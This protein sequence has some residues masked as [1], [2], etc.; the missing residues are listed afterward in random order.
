MKLPN[1]SQKLLISG[2][3]LLAF[4]LRAYRLDFQ[5]YWID[6]G[7]TVF[8]A[9]L[10][11]AELWHLLQVTEIMPP[12]YHPSTIYWI[13][14]A[15]DSEYALRFYSLVFGVLAVPLTYR[16]GKDLGDSRLGLIAAFLMAVSPYQVWHSQEARMYSIFTA[17]SVMSM[18]GFVNLWQRRGPR[19]WAVYIIGTEWAIMTHY[20]AVVL[21][22]IQGL[23]LLL[24]WRKNWRTYPA[25]AA[26]LGV[27]VLLYVPWLIFGSNLL[28]SYINWIEPTP[29]AES[30]LRSAIA[31]SVGELVPRPQ[32]VPLAMVFA[33]VY[34]LGLVYAARRN[35]KNWR[36]PEMLALLVAYTLAPNIAAWVYGELRTVVYFERYLILV[37]VGY[38]LAVSAGVLAVAD[39]LPA[40]IRKTGRPAAAKRAGA[41]AA[42]LVLAVLAGISGW[43][44]Y[45]HYTNPAY[46]KPNWRA[47][48]RTIDAYSLPG[49]AV[50]LT[51][52]GGENLMRFYSQ[53]QTPIYA[54]FNLL[55][56]THP[57]YKKG[58]KG[59][60]ELDQIM[61]GLSARYRRIWFTPYG[62]D[63]DPALEQWLAAHT[64]PAWHNWLGR[65]RLALY[66]TPTQTPALRREQLLAVFGD[67]P[68]ESLTLLSAALPQTAVAAGDVLPLEL[69]W[70][71]NVPPANDYRLS[72]RLVNRQGDIFAQSDWPPLAT[73]GPPSTWPPGQPVSDRRGLWL[74]PDIPPGQYGLQFVV[75]HPGSGRPLGQPANLFG[76]AVSAAAITVAPD[77]L[78]LPN[79]GER[80]L[81]GLN[82]AGYALPETIKPGREMWLW[83]YW[84]APPA[85]LDLPPDTILRLSLSTTEQETPVDFPLAGSVGPF[86]A[87]LPGQVR[88]AVY[89]LPTNPRLTGNQAQLKLA[90]VDAAGRVTAN[91]SLNGPR[92]ETRP[93]R[94]DPPDVEHPAGVAFGHPALLKLV[95]YNVPKNGVAAGN[96]VTV[97]LYWQAVAPINT[98]YTTFVQVLNPAGQVVAQVDMPPQAGNAPTTT[99][100][101]GEFLEDPYSLT[102]PPGLPPGSYRL[103]TGLYNPATAARL[104]VASGGDFVEL[105]PLTVQ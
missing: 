44:L 39:G 77:M 52:D 75:Y 68:E 79:P 49:D 42:G 45:H 9:H 24:T 94:F 41:P 84:Q 36:G 7:W 30:F 72:V 34:G 91:L 96:V 78:S 40:L 92:L 97:T 82:L 62:V 17:T 53:S 70:Q 11:P 25:W 18:W 100:L 43:V 3:A 89:H 50:L 104:P 16:L 90:L 60:A 61:T 67:S 27:M 88:R 23:F 105:P 5:S 66:R 33:A 102:L 57:D 28:Q 14:L 22:G 98:E 54:D 48:A 47:V 4:L 73:A 51:G 46:A 35:W 21:I 20:H 12:F 74:P 19:W 99:W 38:L 26:S 10:S 80:P 81:G 76:V 6:E 95:G 29:L 69:T 101:P 58:R 32:A 15:G 56:P 86:D 64:Y 2:L 63:I 71:T 31:Y 103:I 13:K 59:A 37:Q 8:F 83:L 93:R 85:G 87:W 65:K 1:L 55:P